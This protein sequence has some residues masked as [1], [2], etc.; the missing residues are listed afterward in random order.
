MVDGE[1]GWQMDGNKNAN[2]EN[3]K[4]FNQGLNQHAVSEKEPM[5]GKKHCSW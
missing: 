2:I 5:Q 1:I 4:R 3:T